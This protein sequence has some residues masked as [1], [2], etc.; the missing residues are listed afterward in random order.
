MLSSITAETSETRREDEEKIDWVYEEIEGDGQKKGE[1]SDWEW[2]AGG[3]L[4]RKGSLG[5]S[6]KRARVEVSTSHYLP[7]HHLFKN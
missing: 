1:A 4:K 3:E 7:S 6:G 5:D 2:R